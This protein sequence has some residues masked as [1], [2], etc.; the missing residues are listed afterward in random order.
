MN[1][2]EQAINTIFNF[3]KKRIWLLFRTRNIN[4]AINDSMIKNERIL[5]RLGDH[6]DYDG[7]GNYGR[8]PPQK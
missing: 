4:K 1:K 5:E 3:I 6:M 2:L 8:F 7:M